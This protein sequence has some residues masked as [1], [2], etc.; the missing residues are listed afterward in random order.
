MGTSERVVK[1]YSHLRH[2]DITIN[3]D[4]TSR[5]VCSCEDVDITTQGKDCSFLYAMFMSFCVV[6]LICLGYARLQQV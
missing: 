6:P 5:F 2:N 4:I 1:P 3:N